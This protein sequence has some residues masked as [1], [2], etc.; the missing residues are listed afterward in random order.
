MT[1]PLVPLALLII[2]L[3]SIW[4]YQR[5]ANDIYCVLSAMT[6]VICLIWGFAIA[7]WSIHLLSLLLL[8]RLNAVSLNGA[9]SGE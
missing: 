5:T 7:H 2:A 4:Y 1:L 3:V 8:Y 9:D 6:A